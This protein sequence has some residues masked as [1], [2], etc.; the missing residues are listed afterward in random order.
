MECTV[1]GRCRGAQA[2]SPV[3]EVHRIATMV[4]VE[5]EQKSSMVWISLPIQSDECARKTIPARS[6]TSCALCMQCCT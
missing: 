2:I 3:P 5:H 6:C 1:L 4:A